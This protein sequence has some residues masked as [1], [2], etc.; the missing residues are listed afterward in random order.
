MQTAMLAPLFDPALQ[1]ALAP[2]FRPLLGRNLRHAGR[3]ALFAA[4]GPPW[5]RNTSAVPI[6]ESYAYSNRQERPTHKRH[7]G[8]PARTEEVHG[9]G[10]VP[11]ARCGSSVALWPP[12]P[13]C[14]APSQHPFRAL[15]RRA[16]SHPPPRSVWLRMRA[17]SEMNMVAA[18]LP[19]WTLVPSAVLTKSG[20]LLVCIQSHRIEMHKRLPQSSNQAVPAR[21]GLG[22]LIARHP[23]EGTAASKRRE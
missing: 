12:G 23:C 4:F 20:D 14:Q 19:S 3:A 17:S 21:H 7:Q 10:P 13:E 2:R 5:R 11:A 22:E 16:G 15:E 1:G 9:C 18:I 6:S 8:P